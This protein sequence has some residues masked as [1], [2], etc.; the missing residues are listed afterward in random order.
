MQTKIS[1]IAHISGSKRDITG[2]VNP[3]K[4]RTAA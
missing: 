1:S 4:K 2:G 3:V